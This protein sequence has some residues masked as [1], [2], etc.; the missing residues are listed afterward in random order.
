V[1]EFSLLQAHKLPTKYTQAAPKN[2]SFFAECLPGNFQQ[3]PYNIL[4]NRDK[5]EEEKYEKNRFLCG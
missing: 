4:I 1:V 5:K 2:F 3:K